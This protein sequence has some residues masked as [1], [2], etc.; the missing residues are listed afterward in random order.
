MTPQTVSRERFEALLRFKLAEQKQPK[1]DSIGAR[2]KQERLRLK[3]RVNDFAG[4]L[5]VTRQSITRIEASRHIPDG[6]TLIGLHNAG[7]DIAYV[8]TG[9]RSQNA[10]QVIEAALATY[11]FVASG[12]GA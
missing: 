8:L 5:N 4:L 1:S 6:R 10:E 7:G 2:F 9:N 12:E 3:I 11:D